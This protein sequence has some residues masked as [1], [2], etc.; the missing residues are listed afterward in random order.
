MCV[1]WVKIVQNVIVKKKYSNSCPDWEKKSIQTLVQAAKSVND[2]FMSPLLAPKEVLD[3]N[4]D[5]DND[6]DDYNDESFCKSY[7]YGEADAAI[8]SNLDL[9]IIELSLTFVLCWLW[10]NQAFITT[11]NTI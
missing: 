2:M 3:Y 8:E 9:V 11:S 4:D 10:P 7:E 6:N 5:N 1:W